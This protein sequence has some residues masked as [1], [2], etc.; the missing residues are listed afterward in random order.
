MSVRGGSVS[1]ARRD[2]Q[3]RRR[4]RLSYLCGRLGLSAQAAAAHLAARRFGRGETSDVARLLALVTSARRTRDAREE[5]AWLHDAG[6]LAA[7]AVLLLDLLHPGQRPRASRLGRRVGGPRRAGP[8]VTGADVV[9]WLRIPPGPAV[10]RLLREVR[11]E[12]LRGAVRSRAQARR[13]LVSS[14]AAK[15]LSAVARR[16]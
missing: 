1:L 7:E 4:L 9:E 15:Q 11:I 6:P 14:L 2:P 10:G 3:S 13:W 12:I 8:R 5:W 16:R